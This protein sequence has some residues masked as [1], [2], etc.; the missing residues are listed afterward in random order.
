MPHI[1]TGQNVQAFI[2]TN[3]LKH[4][5]VCTANISSCQLLLNTILWLSELIFPVRVII[6]QLD[7]LTV[8]YVQKHTWQ[9]YFDWSTK[10]VL[11]IYLWTPFGRGG[12]HVIGWRWQ[13]SRPVKLNLLFVIRKRIK[14]RTGGVYIRYS[15]DITSTVSMC[16]NSYNF[17]WNYNPL[18]TGLKRYF[19]NWEKAANLS[20]QANAAWIFFF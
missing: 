17:R 6:S 7:L 14:N 19:K 11:P 10:A 1:F 2:Y 12:V 5:K 9:T 3:V 13:N 4:D 16:E 8:I 15:W 18:L 20:S